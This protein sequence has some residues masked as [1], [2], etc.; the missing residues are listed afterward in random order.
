MATTCLF[1]AET[2]G[3]LATFEALEAPNA[4]LAAA[5]ADDLQI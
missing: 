3:A 1:E 2:A 4:A 5:L